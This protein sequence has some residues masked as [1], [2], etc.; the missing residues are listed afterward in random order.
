MM[1]SK[2]T[3]RKAFF[4]G[5]AALALL[6]G[7]T[8][9]GWGQTAGTG[10]I[11]GTVKDP[12]G[13]VVAGAEVTVKNVST[14]AERKFTT[15]DAGIYLASL[16]QP[17]QYEVRTRK[18]G[19]AEVIRQNV[20]LEVGQTLVVDVEMPLRA[21]Q[22]TITVTSEPGL[23]ETE[24]IEVSQTIS[25]ELVENL[26]LNGRRWDNL[27]LLSPGVG[28]DGGFGGITFRG[29]SSLYNNNMVDGADNNQ[30]F[31]SEA[32]GRTRLAYGYSINSIKEFQV[33]TAVYTA[34]YG[35]AAGGVV[36]AVT[37][38][39]TNNWH[40]DFFY[41]I[42]D[43]A[44]LARDPV[45]NVTP[46]ILPGSTT[47]ITGFKPDERRQQFGGS[48]SGPLA[49]DKI[50]FFLNYDQQRRSFPAIIAPFDATF[51][52]TTISSSQVSQCI[53]QATNITFLGIT[54]TDCTNVVNA[55]QP[56]T[57]T[58]APRRGDQWLG[59]A[60][61]DI[62]ANASNRISAVYNALRWDSPNGILT[63]PV[64]RNTEL[65]NGTDLVTNDYVI[66]TWSSVW[67][68]TV[69]NEAK[70]QWGRDF[71]SQV[72]NGSGPEFQITGPA[73][74]GMPRF[75]PRGKFPN[76]TLWQWA[77][78]LSWQRGRAEWK[79]GVDI[80][81]RTNDIQNL[82]NGGGQYGYTGSRTI[83][84]PGAPNVTGCSPTFDL[85]TMTSGQSCSLQSMTRFVTDLVTGSRTYGS[86]TQAVDPVTGDGLGKFKT[87]DYNF[88]AQFNIKWRPNVKINLGVRYELQDLPDP[89]NPNPAIPENGVLNTDTNNFGPRVGF[90]WA[91]GREQKQV[92]RGGYG[93]YYGRTQNSTVFV[94]LFQNG[95]T[96]VTFNFSGSGASGTPNTNPMTTNYRSS[97]PSCG[98]PQAPNTTFPQPSTVPALTPIF[99]TTGPTPTATFSSLAAF[100]MLC[101]T[102]TPASAVQTL[103]PDYVNPLVHQYDVAYEAE[104]PWKLGLT[105]SY[106]GSRGNHL[107]VFYDDNLPAPSATRT[108]RVFDGA[109]TAL[110]IDASGATQFSVPFFIVNAQNP[111]PRAAGLDGIP[112]NAD[113]VNFPVILG[114]SVVNSWY[115]G[116]VV[117]VRRREYKGFSFDANFTWSRAIDNG[118]VAGV[119]GTFAQGVPILNP[120]DLRSEYG[121]SEIDIR[122]RFIMNTYWMLPFGDKVTQPFLKALVRDWLI[123]SVW[124]IQDGRPVTALMRGRPSCTTGLGGLTCGA[125]GNVGAPVDGRVPFIKRNTIFTSPSLIT[126]DLRTT[127]IVRITEGSSLELYWEAFNIFNR[128]NAVPSS[129][130]FAVNEQ[131][132]DFVSSGSSIATGVSCSAGTVPTAE[133]GGCLVRRTPPRVSDAD[134]FLNIRSTGNTLYTARQMQ[135][136]FK[137]RF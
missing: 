79:F 74:F 58:V 131:M 51:A 98:A 34:E 120:H 30:A 108:Y 44:F 109:G 127:R 7:V 20:R 55:L 29:I 60:K 40:G 134:R 121:I 117:R 124:K 88:Y 28:E 52:D 100:Q 107:P 103:S 96:Q 73:N 13:A 114:R 45:G 115:N 99:G 70:F 97:A 37:K 8:T 67:T 69:V 32:R 68:Q 42:R 118:H 111:R 89:V 12:S 62:Q 125:A 54:P 106:V 135:F 33:Q 85:T 78:N 19:F 25:Q 39:G 6:L 84:F 47:A 122:R 136:G 86:F 113:D 71:E 50:F 80:N 27:A 112:G 77:D 17:G 14:G 3:M 116:L 24:K 102:T 23:V 104:L 35:R 119:N 105:V 101:G 64:L 123:T 91:L 110:P 46:V 59:L 53:T 130:I 49:P 133:F 31:F 56:L 61:V 38:S 90:S 11:S 83:Y 57:A 48:F 63:G 16:L 92:I 93:M 10:A 95:L 82:F 1:P 66:V 75:L 87:T 128:T 21:A 22:E 2:D 5:V 36:N 26:P 126:F 65:N 9:T 132:F 72:P 41:F 18:E 129:G 76:E 43:K 81:R 94:H 15:N 137:I 4:A